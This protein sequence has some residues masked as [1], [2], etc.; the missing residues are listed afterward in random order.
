MKTELV[1]TK[2]KYE[3]G[4]RTAIEAVAELLER[5]DKA[6]V[7]MEKAREEKELVTFVYWFV[8]IHEYY[9][10]LLQEP[11]F[12][13][14]LKD[15]YAEIDSCIPMD[16]LKHK[17]EH[18]YERLPHLWFY[19]GYSI[20]DM[21]GCA[22]SNRFAES[23]FNFSPDIKMMICGGTLSRQNLMLHF[24]RTGERREHVDFCD[25][26]GK[27][28]NDQPYPYTYRCTKCGQIF[29]LCAK[30]SEGQIHKSWGNIGRSSQHQYKDLVYRRMF[31]QDQK[32]PKQSDIDQSFID[33]DVLKFTEG[34]QV[35]ARE[36]VSVV[37]KVLRRIKEK[38][39]IRYYRY[40]QECRV[41]YTFNDSNI[42]TMCVD[43]CSNIY[44][45]ANYLY[46][47][48]KMDEEL[49]YALFMNGLYRIVYDMFAQERNFL[50]KGMP[51]GGLFGL[52]STGWGKKCSP[53]ELTK[54]LHHDIN[55]TLDLLTNSYL[56]S[57]EI[58]SY[59]SLK[60]RMNAICRNTATTSTIGRY[61]YHDTMGKFKDEVNQTFP[62][63]PSR[64]PIP[65]TFLSGYIQTRVRIGKLVVSYGEMR[66]Y[67]KLKPIIKYIRKGNLQSL[68]DMF[69]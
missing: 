43:E 15:V 42:K 5:I 20:S 4:K 51:R 14:E 27:N 63:E 45:S 22:L 31:Q 67:E 50:S 64:K 28:L 48:L 9:Y 26:C 6:T 33:N 17:R 47:V 36:I 12:P 13:D 34:G 7:N 59:D 61:Y 11:L 35:E 52:Y 44:V 32:S 40:L 39:D 66:T 3:Q 68:Q 29:N 1:N 24:L 18:G 69:N 23:I 49:I 46:R 19:G 37:G 38:Y 53:I 25:V 16:Y 58:L 8:L 30:C 60:N 21:I 62:L 2:S 41:L 56:I 55:I 10:L 57:N 65:N 54:P